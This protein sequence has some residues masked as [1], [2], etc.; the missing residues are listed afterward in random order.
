[1][2]DEKTGMSEQAEWLMALDVLIE[3]NGTAY[4]ADL[5]SKLASHVG[6]QV[7]SS[8]WNSTF[9]TQNIDIDACQKASALVR[10]NAAFIVQNA[11]QYG[12]EIGGHIS[13]FASSY[14]L[15][16]IG[17]YYFFKGSDLALGDLVF[18]QG[19]ASPGN[20][21]SSYLLAE[22][23]LEQIKNFRRESTGLGV[24]SYP[25]PWLMP[26]YWQ[27]P[28]VSMGLGPLAAIYQAKL[29][30]YLAARGLVKDTSRQVYA[31]LGDG[32]MDEVESMG[33]L[34]VATREK[35][36]NLIF[37]V[38]CNLVRLDGP[39]RGNGQIIQEL[40]QYFSGYGWNVIKLVWSQAWLDL[41]S[42]DKKGYLQEKLMALKDGEIQALYAN[43]DTLKSWFYDDDRIAS[44]VMG[45][46]D[47]DFEKLLPGGH[48]LQLV[49][50]AYLTAKEA[51]EPCVM[52]I[53]TEKGHG[54]KDISS[55]NISHNKKQLSEDQLKAYLQF[56]NLETEVK[57]L[58]FYHPGQS[59]ARIQFMK[60][61]RKVL[62][63]T[64]PKR[65]A[66]SSLLKIPKAKDLVSSLKLDV[67]RSFSTTMAFVRI[68]NAWLGDS[69]IKDRVVPILADEGRT[70]GMEGLF[71][72][73]GIYQ[74]GGQLYTPHDHEEISY[75]RESPKGQLIQ[76]G[77]NEAGAMS[78]WAACATSYSVHNLPLIPI[79]AYYSMFGFQRVGDIIHAAADSRSR[80]FLMGGTAGKTTLGG[81][82]LQH[83][84]GTSLLMASTI[85]NC[86]SYDPCFAYELAIIMQ[87]GLEQMYAKDM[88]VFYYITMMNENYPQPPMPKGIESDI[89]KGMYLIHDNN[90]SVD[91][92]ASGT[93]LRQAMMAC[94]WLKH[95]VGVSVRVWSVTSY[96]E[97]YREAELA[98]QARQR[99]Y[100]DECLDDS[101]LVIACSD[102]V[103]ALPGLIHE[104]VGRR[105]VTVGTDGFGMSDTRQELREYYGVS[106]RDI[107]I[108][109]LES[110]VEMGLLDGAKVRKWIKPIKTPHP[111]QDDR[112]K[113]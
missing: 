8:Y 27:F 3:E 30:K 111:L 89:I 96:C 85:P 100:V 79:Y 74:P 103:K 113:T 28:T 51:T 106:K 29:I 87:H 104:H 16:E 99:S 110:M 9:K 101:Q 50:N 25:H 5:I 92:L 109:V 43:L 21:A 44:L 41:V 57:K 47:D 68:L 76:E 53:M 62:G 91:I 108:T 42:V 61:R 13:T 75:Y 60:K 14:A 17:Q 56:L 72:K 49:A 35:L 1:M 40:G 98:K 32:E 94:E 39:C 10:W 2:Q 86:K 54:L 46:Q 71:A 58:D 81:E 26:H 107:A 88:D 80:G 67:S 65:S 82:G 90:A 78:M 63:G 69:S 45:W 48:D 84:D 6:Q 19:H 18:F 12:S 11:A 33:A 34:G 93:I 7:G 73:I 64:L 38:N 97:L 77:L 37:I 15:V 95:E 4:G 102:Y 83:N 31:L 66:S 52:L 70:F 20:Y 105:M 59:D 24:S 23:S 36:D 22:L 112:R 55:R